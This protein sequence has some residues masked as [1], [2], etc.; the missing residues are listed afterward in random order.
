MNAVA[1]SNEPQVLHADLDLPFEIRRMRW[2]NGGQNILTT[3]RVTVE[4]RYFDMTSQ[5]RPQF[6]GAILKLV[7][8]YREAKGL[9]A[10]ELEPLPEPWRPVEVP[11]RFLTP[12]ETEEAVAKAEHDAKFDALGHLREQPVG[13]GFLARWQPVAA[14]SVPGVATGEGIT[15]P[16]PGNISVA[17]TPPLETKQVVNEGFNPQPN[18]QPLMGGCVTPVAIVPEQP[19]NAKRRKKG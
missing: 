13:E 16:P 11:E 14:K 5:N 1:W 10:I 9:P 15:C 12:Q 3:I 7:E 18:D 17:T 6:V 2:G 19:D 4:G 8:Q